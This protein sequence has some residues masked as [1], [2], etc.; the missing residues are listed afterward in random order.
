MMVGRDSCPTIIQM[1]HRNIPP[2]DIPPAQADVSVDYS[3]C[4]V[5]SPEIPLHPVQ[6]DRSTHPAI[7]LLDVQIAVEFGEQ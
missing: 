1:Y 3:G 4:I 5:P 6:F 7:W 2:R